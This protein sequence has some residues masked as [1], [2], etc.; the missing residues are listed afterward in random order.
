MGVNLT[1]F[2]ID[3]EQRRR[4]I[5]S[6]EGD[7]DEE[8][9][10]AVEEVMPELERAYGM[11]YVRR[12]D[13]TWDVIHFLLTEETSETNG[14][15]GQVLGIEATHPEIVG[16]LG[17][18]AGIADEAQTRALAHR[19]D[20][21]GEDTMRERLGRVPES[22][23]NGGTGGTDARWDDDIVADAVD[24]ASYIG[25]SADAGLG[26]LLIVG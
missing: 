11:W 1:V 12:S 13:K 20:S 7:Y 14:S 24:L 25:A 16:N 3:A 21:V 19:M 5:V 2:G 22:V 10:E 6:T 18:W 23:Y 9:E 15:T 26:L 4:L 17:W 8:V